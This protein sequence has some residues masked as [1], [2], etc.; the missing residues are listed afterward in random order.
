MDIEN[1][2][3]LVV[4]DSEINRVFL[5]EYLGQIHDYQVLCAEDGKCAIALASSELPGLILLDINMPG[6]DGIEVCTIL[7]KIPVVDKIPVIFLTTRTKP[8]DRIS[9]FLS[10]GVDY[11]TRPFDN[12]ELV[13]RIRTHLEMYQL[14]LSLEE[15]SKS[16]AQRQKEIKQALSL[17]N[18]F[19]K[20][21]DGPHKQIL[22]SLEEGVIKLNQQGFCLFANDAAA[23]VLG[24]R[25]PKALIGEVVYSKVPGINKDKTPVANNR[26]LFNKTIH[27]RDEVWLRNDGSDFPVEY[28]GRPLSEG[29]DLAALVVI[30]F[31]D[32]SMQKNMETKIQALAYRDGLTGLP[33]RVVFFEALRQSIDF[34]KQYQNNFAIFMLDMDHFKEVNDSLGH[35]A[36]DEVLCQMARRLQG[37]APSPDKV[38]RLSGDEFA[39]IYSDFSSVNDVRIMA[40]GMQQILNKPYSY[41]NMPLTSSVSV[42]IYIYNNVNESIEDIMMRADLALYQVKN[43]CRGTFCIFEDDMLDDMEAEIEIS[44]D[45]IGLIERN[46]LQVE[47]QPQIDL[48]TGGYAGAEALVRW[49]HPSR[50]YLLPSAFLPIAEKRGYIK[51]ISDWVLQ[52]VARQASEWRQQGLSFGEISINICASQIASESFE[53][54]IRNIFKQNNIKPRDLVLELTETVQFHTHQRIRKSLQ[55]LT[56]LGVRF[57][58]DDFGTGYSSVKLL[59]DL[60]CDKIKIDY[61]FIEGIENDPKC[62]DIITALIKLA[63]VLNMEVIAE[64]VENIKQA[65]FLLKNGCYIVQ[66]FYY[67]SSLKAEEL[68]RNY[69]K[70]M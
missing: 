35:Q 21:E 32:I 43:S 10:G 65:E 27:K 59:K 52:E 67:A 68:E 39:L 14:R 24:Y 40:D 38:A 16:H 28:R 18:S 48:R 47:Y 55:N 49:N 8:K 37:C 61:T 54:Q 29:G 66:G 51:E 62:P 42:G 17:S 13:R 34:F 2:K 11:M 5:E 45:F 63:H 22:S 9:G 56:E 46:E 3:I 36:G 12:G 69:F 58:I 26:D 31:S 41:R 53:A 19:L 15:I 30:S 7:K 50:G 57:A 33:N 20:R 1:K 64:G 23:R 44:K 25:S 70:K 60:H 4:D 6:M